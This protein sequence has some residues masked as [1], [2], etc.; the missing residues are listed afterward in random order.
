MSLNSCLLGNTAASPVSQLNG[1]IPVS[2]F[3]ADIPLYIPAPIQCHLAKRYLPQAIRAL[4]FSPADELISESAVSSPKASYASGNPA[5]VQNFTLVDFRVF[6]ASHTLFVDYLLRADVPASPE[7]EP[8]PETPVFRVRME[9]DLSCGY[10]M[11][12]FQ[13]PVPVLPQDPIPERPLNEYLLSNGNKNYLRALARDLST[14]CRVGKQGTQT[15][16]TD[17][18]LDRMG[19]EL[20]PVSLEPG[21]GILGQVC[22]GPV[23]LRDPK[24]PLAEEQFRQDDTL[25]LNESAC[26]GPDG[27]F[28]PQR[29]DE[30]I[31]LACCHLRLHRLFLEGQ[32]LLNPELRGITLFEVQGK[33]RMA[34]SETPIAV[35]V[36]PVPQDPIPEPLALAAEQARQMAKYLRS[37]KIRN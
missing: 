33:Y 18:L 15:L 5:S 16:S 9:A 13:D 2:G 6:R 24:N 30:I 1:E 37:P 31:S 17:L 32:R 4:A 23:T 34:L 14:G 25:F 21:S 8:Q 29:R 35:G 20:C 27:T 7:E 22:L 19:L 28:C 10:C 26:V 36:P 11:V 12:R 3:D